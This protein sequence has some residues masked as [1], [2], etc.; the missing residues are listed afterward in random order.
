[1]LWGYRYSFGQKSLESIALDKAKGLLI[2]VNVCVLA[3]LYFV[4][5]MVFGYS[6]YHYVPAGRGGGDFSAASLVKVRL[7]GDSKEVQQD[8]LC[9]DNDDKVLV[10]VEGTNSSIFVA[11]P[12]EKGSPENWR[13]GRSSRPRVVEIPR[14]EIDRIEY[15]NV[16]A[17]EWIAKSG[18]DRS[19]N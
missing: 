14:S 10:V 8:W 13:K 15:L 9:F 3:I 2:G 6:I 7:K 4:M 19:A 17:K 1:M 12:T 18:R 5:V 11:K 16:S